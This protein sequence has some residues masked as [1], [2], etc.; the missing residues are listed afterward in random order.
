M[1]SQVIVEDSLIR[2]EGISVQN[3]D[4]VEYFR[5]RREEDRALAAIRAIELGVFCLQRAEVGQSLEFVKLEVERLIQAA[6]RAV[7]KLPE[8]IRSKLS[9]QDSPTAQ[10][11]NTV[12]SAQDSVQSKLDEVRAL[13]STHLDPTKGDATLGKALNALNALLDPRRDGSV[14]KTVDAT[15]LSLAGVDGSISQAVRTTVDGVVAPLRTAIETLSLAVAKA[16]GT[17]EALAVSPE[18]GFQF[19]DELLPVL[20]NW[21]GSVGAELEHVGPQNEPG[22]FVLTMRDTSICGLPLKIVIEARD[23]GQPFGRV[24]I[25]KQMTDALLSWKGN[26]GI[27]VSKTPGGLAKEVGEWAEFGCE[28]GPVVAC[29]VEHLK[30]AVRFAIV[31]ARLRAAAQQ[32]KEVD[33]RT[34]ATELGRFRDSLNHLTQIKR[35][36][37]EIRQ[38]LD[39][40]P[41]IETVKTIFPAGVFVSICSENETKSIPRASKVSSACNRSETERANLSNRH[42]QTA[43]N[44]RLCASA[45]SRLSSGRESFAPLTP[46]SM[47]SPTICHPRASANCRSSRV[48]IETS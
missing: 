40:L 5:S 6:S 35:K 4:V 22:D 37:G 18:K 38:I 30:T 36:V 33:T 23:R 8:E 3:P 39:V 20:Q 47:Y 14:Q 45:I 12:Q 43:S 48:C 46:A 7:D 1:P 21:A 24:L 29:T 13:F 41:S 16:A 27:Y 28:H 11:S 42:T 32:K 34:V 17:Q 15:V 25:A 2:I 44:R 26:F 19:E 9:G 10:I 31:D